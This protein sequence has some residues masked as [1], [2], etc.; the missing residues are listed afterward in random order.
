[1]TAAAAAHNLWHTAEEA[2]QPFCEQ[3]QYAAVAWHEHPCM[4][5]SCSDMHTGQHLMFPGVRRRSPA[6]TFLRAFKVSFSG[7]CTRYPRDTA[8]Q[9]LKSLWTWSHVVSKSLGLAASMRRQAPVQ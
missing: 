8:V 3:S 2:A 7:R 1:M 5:A 6:A 9:R 4:V